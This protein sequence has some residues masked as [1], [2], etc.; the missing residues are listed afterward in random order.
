MLILSACSRATECPTWNNNEANRQITHL[1]AEVRRHDELYHR[2]NNPEISDDEYDALQ[3]RLVFLQRC[4][5]DISVQHYRPIAEG[6]SLQHHHFMGSLRKAAGEEDIKAFFQKFSESGIILQ[7]KIDGIAV[8]LIYKNGVL[9]KAITR[10][11]GEYGKSI[12][13]HVKYMTLIP[14]Q[15]PE[16][17]DLVLH[18]ELFTRLDLVDDNILKEYASARHMVA[19]QV[20]RKKP[21]QEVLKVIDFFP[22][23]WI[24][25]PFASEAEA[26]DLLDKLGFRHTAK[27]THNIKTLK[28][29]L[30]WREAYSDK[31]NK[32]FLMDGIVLKSASTTHRED[33]G[34]NQ[35]YPDRALAWKFPAKAIVTT[36]IDI[37]FSKGATGKVTPVLILSPVTVEGRIIQ[38]VSLGSLDTFQNNGIA[39]GD[40]V[41]VK[42]KGGATPVFEKVV[43]RNSRKKG[44]SGLERK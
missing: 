44:G 26:I 7:P 22:W 32:I 37:E 20:N 15:L 31:K 19:G 1:A 9:T 2:Q 3:T 41:S 28:D 23:R 24:D 40:Q 12:I 11:D 38:R 6:G 34:R 42:L 39:V 33:S 17:V 29:I 30:R 25:V 16:A 13:H 14:Q 8:E 4:Y 35:K 18:G 36:V 27:Y 21:A 5:P 10:G 43:F